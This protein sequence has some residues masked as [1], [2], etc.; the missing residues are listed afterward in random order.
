M[1]E[2]SVTQGGD[3]HAAAAALGDLGAAPESEL[4][5]DAALLARRAPL[6]AAL[7]AANLDVGRYYTGRSK[8]SATHFQQFCEDYNI[9]LPSSCGKVR[10]LRCVCLPVAMAD[11]PARA[12]DLLLHAGRGEAAE[13]AAAACLGGDA[14]DARVGGREAG[15]APGRAPLLQALP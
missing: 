7:D 10:A 5:T 9:L 2:D 15:C 1:S 13:G 8:K 12:G 4:R 3:A 14:L 11:A 6:Q